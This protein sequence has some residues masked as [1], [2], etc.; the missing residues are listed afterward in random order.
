MTYTVA[1]IVDRDA[2]KLVT[3]LAS[4]L[5]VWACFTEPNSTAAAEVWS[6]EPS[7]SLERG[8]TGL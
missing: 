8:V 5:H 2:G 3:D 4:G 6:A 1:I 7:Y